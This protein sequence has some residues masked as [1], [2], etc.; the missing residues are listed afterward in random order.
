MTTTQRFE[1]Q[2]GP[3]PPYAGALY[4]RSRK[5]T[6]HQP[7]FEVGQSTPSP[8]AR[9]A[10]PPFRVKALYDYSSKEEDDLKFPNGQVILVTDEEDADWYYGEYEDAAGEKQEGLFPKNFVKV[11]EPDMPP[12][13]TR[14]GR[15]KKDNDTPA[16]ASEEARA[17]AAEEPEAVPAPA[18]IQSAIIPEQT[19]EEPEPPVSQV[20][21]TET[22][23]APTQKPAPPAAPK[24]PPPPAAEK[25]ASGSFRDRINAF[26]KSTAPPP[27]PNKPSGLGASGGS[28]FV[29]KAFVAPPPSKNAYVPPPREPPPQKVYRREEDPEIVAQASNDAEN[30]VQIAQ[31]QVA[32]SAEAEEDQPKPTSLKDRIA[33][34]QKQQM[35]QAARHAEASQKKDKPKR[36]P[37]KQV[38]PQAPAADAEDDVE[39]EN[40]ERMNSTETTGKRSIEASRD[41]VSSGARHPKHPKSQ[42]ATPVASPTAVASR[43][44]MSDPNDADQSGIG[45]TEDGEDLST[46][47][48][49]SDENPRRRIS[50]PPQIPSQAPLREADVGDEEDNADE[51]GAEEEEEHVDPEV[52]RRMEIRER[53]AKMSGGMGMAGMFGPPGG[54]APRAP[55]RRGTASGERNISSNSV[56]AQADDGSSSRALPVPIMPMPGLQKVRSPE[57]H[58]AQP[59][60]TKEEAGEAKSVIQGRDS[61][62]MPDVE[63]MEEPIPTPRRSVDRL[64]PPP[65]PQGKLSRIDVLE[66]DISDI[67]QIA[68]FLLRLAKVEELLPLCLS[69][70]RSRLPLA[71]VSTVHIGHNND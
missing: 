59:E 18:P 9:M 7:D 8:S 25:P 62:D 23:S 4:S 35:E 13:P 58:G 5:R 49:D 29:K 44:F 54:I 38:E 41:A 61:E 50:I 3:W 52:K 45:D 42:E 43:D 36:P 21:R 48:D 51:D 33:L 12:R 68:L 6:T 64:A 56:S 47:R 53:M 60:V 71:N 10:T 69:I 2:F 1:A 30:E 32:A 28:G 31:P 37:K 20:V 65:V 24:P 55:T 14:S 57:Q 34:L 16:L 40:L 19:F 15:S 63:D 70:D 39:G 11:F 22:V 67:F 26:N 66:L 17:P 27:A 46:G